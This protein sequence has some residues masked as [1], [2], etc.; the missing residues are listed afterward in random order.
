[1][2]A[3]QLPPTDSE[4][5]VQLIN[6]PNEILVL[7]VS[8][9]DTR[10]VLHL[11][12]VCRR[13]RAVVGD[14]TGPQWSAIRWKS[15]NRVKDADG[16]KLALRLCKKSLTELSLVS[17]GHQ[18]RMSSCIQQITTCANLQSIT[19]D[20]VIYTPAQIG[21][22]LQLPSLRSFYV[23]ASLRSLNLDSTSKIN[24]CFFEVETNGRLETLSLK[25]A[26]SIL[27]Y[28]CIQ[29]WV[30]ASYFPSDL[31]LFVLH[32][33]KIS[34]P[35]HFTHFFPGPVTGAAYVSVY[36]QPHSKGIVSPHLQFQCQF[37]PEG[38]APFFCSEK[39][40]SVASAKPGTG[41]MVYAKYWDETFHG[42]VVFSDICSGLSEL[43]VSGCRSLSLSDLQCPNLVRLDLESCGAVLSNLD[44]LHSVAVNCAKLRVLSLLDLHQVE[45]LERLWTILAS[46]SNLKVLYLSSDLLIQHV[47]PGHTIPVPRL[48]AISID[49]KNGNQ[50]CNKLGFLVNISSLEILKLKELHEIQLSELSLLMR[51]Y[52]NLTHLCLVS[53]RSKLTLPRDPACY[54]TLQEL[55]VADYRF[56][57]HDDLARTLAQCKNLSVLRLQIA[58]FG[59][60]DNIA[61]IVKS[62]ASLSLCYLFMQEFEGKSLSLARANKRAVALTKSVTEAV[63]K[64]GRT[65]DFKICGVLE[66]YTY[67]SNNLQFPV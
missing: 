3:V 29:F 57:V 37:S 55:F 48:T 43:D 15:S 38:I 21:K 7:I 67:T 23:D 42:N 19:L 54:S 63:K 46:M 27:L 61:K 28:A 4:S 62:V 59:T 44:G 40:L 35:K 58:G 1:M 12:C 14:P 32:K 18:F 49:G 56:I 30:H 47:V 31:R 66:G 51:T 20:G 50:I 22:L 36:Y 16:F 24:L 60:S 34:L 8:F 25:L 53:T 64:D 45:S 9:L 65:I 6:L 41:D 13:L 39:Q 11:T 17:R 33:P 26:T 2:A 10:T 52:T 5:C